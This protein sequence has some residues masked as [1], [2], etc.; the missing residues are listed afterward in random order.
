MTLFLWWQPPSEDSHWKNGAD[1]ISEDFSLTHERKKNTSD[2]KFT[3]M[4]TKKA[5]GRVLKISFLE[6]QQLILFCHVN[7]Q[8]RRNLVSFSVQDLFTKFLSK[9]NI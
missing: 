1:L 3:P 8:D 5:L 2:N 9:L 4:F 6:T 7:H